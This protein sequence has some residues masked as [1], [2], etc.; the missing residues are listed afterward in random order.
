[1]WRGVS[2]AEKKEFGCLNFSLDKFQEAP[3]TRPEAPAWMCPWGSERVHKPFARRHG[4]RRSPQQSGS[5]TGQPGR[6]K[7][8]VLYSRYE[9]SAEVDLG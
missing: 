3:E 7:R 5:H 2:R 8:G 6:S 9:E 4:L 1:M